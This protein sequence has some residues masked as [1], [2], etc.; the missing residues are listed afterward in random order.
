MASSLCISKP[1][2]NVFVCDPMRKNSRNAVVMYA[3]EAYFLCSMHEKCTDFLAM[4]CI[5]RR[6]VSPY[7]ML[8]REEQDSGVRNVSTYLWE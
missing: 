6:Y 1:I 7:H 2:K 8:V 4:S 5:T 3:S